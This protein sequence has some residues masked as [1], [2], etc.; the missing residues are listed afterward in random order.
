MSSNFSWFLR[1]VIYIPLTVAI[2]FMVS[3]SYLTSRFDKNFSECLQKVPLNQQ[4][5]S[6]REM[7]S[8]VGC[9]KSKGNFFI[10]RMMREER[11]YQYTQPKMQCELVGKWYVSDGYQ[12][13]WLTIQSDSRFF[14][15]PLRNAKVQNETI[16]NK[17]IWSSADKQTAIQFFDGEYFWPIHEYKMNWLSDRHFALVNILED[18]QIYFYRNSSLDQVCSNSKNITKSN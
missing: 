1:F 4:N 6:A 16:L 7:T 12:E 13:Y 17:G 2:L 9:L 5:V 15:E 11:L 14:T 10:S 18:K 8:F 3:Y